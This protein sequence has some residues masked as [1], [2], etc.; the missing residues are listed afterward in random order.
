MS[1]HSTLGN[2]LWSQTFRSELWKNIGVGQRLGDHQIIAQTEH[3]A[4]E[5]DGPTETQEEA[6]S[7]LEEEIKKGDRRYRL[8]NCFEF[9]NKGDFNMLLWVKG[10]KPESER[11]R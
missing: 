3:C 11:E 9:L 5:E 4:R 7:R 2:I 1:A 6:F 8:H 10:K